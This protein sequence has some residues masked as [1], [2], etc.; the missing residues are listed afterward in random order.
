MGYEI[1]PPRSA[2]TPQAFDWSHQQH[3]DDED[4]ED[5]DDDEED[6]IR[7]FLKT[8]FQDSPPISGDSKANNLNSSNDN[9]AKNESMER[10]GG[11]WSLE[12][13]SMPTT[14]L[15]LSSESSPDLLAF[16]QPIVWPVVG[17][18]GP[19]KA[20]AIDMWRRSLLSPLLMEDVHSRHS[21]DQDQDLQ[22]MGVHKSNI[23]LG[24]RRP[25]ADHTRDR[26]EPGFI[27]CDLEY[28]DDRG[29]DP[30]LS[31]QSRSKW[32]RFKEQY[33]RPRLATDSSS[34]NASADG[35]SDYDPLPMYDRPRQCSL[36]PPPCHRDDDNIPQSMTGR[37]RHI[38]LGGHEIRPGVGPQDYFNSRI[39]ISKEY[40]ILAQEHAM[41]TK[42]YSLWQK[43][44][45]SSEGDSGTDRDSYTAQY[46]TPDMTGAS[47][48]EPP[49]RDSYMNL[50]HR[51]RDLNPNLFKNGVSDIYLLPSKPL[52]PKR[53]Q[54]ART[55]ISSKTTESGVKK[56]GIL[57]SILKRPS[58]PGMDTATL[59]AAVAAGAS[60]AAISKK[61]RIV[62]NQPSSVDMYPSVSDPSMSLH[63]SS[64]SYLP[65]HDPNFVF[66]VPSVAP[67]MM[68]IAPDQRFPEPIGPLSIPSS[69]M[70]KHVFTPVRAAAAAVRHPPVRPPRR[71]PV[72][73]KTP[74]KA[75]I[76]VP[77]FGGM[78]TSSSGI[79]YGKRGSLSSPDLVSPIMAQ[80][81]IHRH[82]DGSK[83]L[84][85][86]QPEDMP[87][88]N[89]APAVTFLGLGLD[90]GEEWNSSKE[91]HLTPVPREELRL[92]TVVVNTLTEP[93]LDHQKNVNMN[94]D[95]DENEREEQRRR[96]EKERATPSPPMRHV[97][98]QHQQLRH[99]Q[100]QR[101]QQ[102]SKVPGSKLSAPLLRRYSSTTSFRKSGLMEKHL[103]HKDDENSSVP[104]DE[105]FCY[106]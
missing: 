102:D 37:R 106:F 84:G 42:R 21:E 64:S 46:Q 68:P 104:S 13:N 53:T 55:N 23:I 67:R 24:G 101:Q 31:S 86:P 99:P 39:P 20:A 105:R 70:N 35:A 88:R 76:G 47:Y 38:N 66:P 96:K 34:S 95:D 75:Y 33:V 5:D 29:I 2:F 28:A 51:E 49:S 19:A 79:P 9:T 98:A 18:M 7:V 62:V 90:M 72:E 100:E 74:G 63:R 4:D 41:A 71:H 14:D 92:P 65:I 3:D 89:S 52:P 59:A 94:V 85:P 36:Q 60:S 50:T 87:R 83:F 6:N 25:S 58:L 16:R 78:A 44:Q 61:T 26:M 57:T 40:N 48:A 103:I 82:H 54:P 15:L 77:E 8:S 91:L 97:Q 17:S 30:P 32:F 43:S 80:S 93:R 12:H 81:S 10:Q 22:A 27:G 69:S 45:L 11:S 1:P 56:K 73:N